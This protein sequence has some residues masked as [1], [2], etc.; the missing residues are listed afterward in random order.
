M[1]RQIQVDDVEAFYSKKPARRSVFD[2]LMDVGTD[3]TF[4]Q[5]EDFDKKVPPQNFI[6]RARGWVRDVMPNCRVIQRTHEDNSVTLRAVELT[7][8]EL[9]ERENRRAENRRRLAAKK[10]RMR[11][12]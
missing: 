5:G 10:L 11:Q 3:W 4:V 2:C 8:E 1:P 6:S 7:Q 12:A 9:E